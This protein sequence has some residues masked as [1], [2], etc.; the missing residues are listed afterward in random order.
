[1]YGRNRSGPAALRATDNHVDEIL[2]LLQ[3]QRDLLVG[4]PYSNEQIAKDKELSLR[5]R[6]L[7]DRL[8][9]SESAPKTER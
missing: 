9:V 1:M 2:R 8:W 7:V 6:R 4:W 3:Q 5:I